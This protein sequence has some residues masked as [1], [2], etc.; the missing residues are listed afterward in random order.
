LLLFIRYYLKGNNAGTTEVFIDG[1]PGMPDNIKK[2]GKFFYIPLGFSRM[3]VFDYIGEYPIIRMMCFKLFRTIDI[4]FRTIDL[5][6][7]H[8]FWKKAAFWVIY[9]Y[10][11]FFL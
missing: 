2:I 3:P 4:T 1:L 9:L 5:Y 7:P 6:F 11:H 8:V 10:I